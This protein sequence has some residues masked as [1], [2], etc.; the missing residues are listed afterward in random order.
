MRAV[1]I[2][3][4]ITKSIERTKFMLFRPFSLKKWLFL[5]LIASLAGATGGG[6]NFNA[7]SH[8]KRG[9][10][11][12]AA[13][14]EKNLDVLNTEQF[15]SEYWDER[16][17]IEMPDREQYASLDTKSPENASFKRKV[18]I[19]AAVIVIALI[20]SLGVLSIWL[21]ARF[22]FVWFEAM[23]KNDA[24]VKAPFREY[25][26][27]GNSL[28]RFFLILTG[29]G[30]LFFG[31]LAA[32]GYLAGN[33]AGVFGTSLS[34]SPVQAFLAFAPPVFTG[35][36]VLIALAVL[37]AFID[38]FI[39]TIMAMDRCL[40]SP[41]WKKFLIIA[42]QNKKDMALF[43]LTLFWMGITAMILAGLIIIAVILASLLAAGIVFGVLYLILAVLLKAKLLFII[44]SVV[45]GIPAFIALIMLMALANLPFA[46]FF[47]NFSLYYITSLGCGYAPLAL[48]NNQGVVEMGEA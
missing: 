40:F 4:L 39:V 13:Q 21:G 47:R 9:E 26:K 34:S 23:V 42:G 22:R 17:E 5:L 2:Q 11:A 14:V 25:E 32:W 27:E 18:M 1:K 7:G 20:I 10:K 46:V 41:A 16:Y 28:F 48:E 45:L 29:L 35:I 30:L 12:E 38:H 31:A 44:L 19:V 15:A 33:A 3:D 43:V 8:G 36:A 6:A 37:G 24:S